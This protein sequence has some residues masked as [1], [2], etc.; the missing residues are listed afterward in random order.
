MWFSVFSHCKLFEIVGIIL[1]QGKFLKFS[2]MFSALQYV[3]S[4]HSTSHCWEVPS[5]SSSSFSSSFSSLLCWW[6][7]VFCRNIFVY[8]LIEWLVEFLDVA[9]ICFLII[10]VINRNSCF[11]KTPVFCLWRH[12]LCHSCYKNYYVKD[13]YEIHKFDSRKCGFHV[14]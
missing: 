1:Y 14:G 2:Y 12:L 10:Q 5:C 13:Q 9:F 7:S 11:L 6:F 3:F 4:L 8:S